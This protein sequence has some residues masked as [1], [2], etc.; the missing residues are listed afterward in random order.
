MWVIESKSQQ[1][2]L[3]KSISSI[4][5]ST[6]FCMNTLNL[7]MQKMEKIVANPEN[8][9]AN[10]CQTRDS[11]QPIQTQFLSCSCSRRHEALVIVQESG[12]SKR[13]IVKL[14]IN[15]ILFTGR[16]ELSCSAGNFRNI[17][18][19]LHR[20]AHNSVLLLESLRGRNSQTQLAPLLFLKRGCRRRQP[21]GG[22][23]ELISLS[24]Y[25]R[26]TGLSLCGGFRHI[27]ETCS[28]NRWCRCVPN[29]AM[30]LSE[31]K[32]RPHTRT[33]NSMPAPSYLS[34][35]PKMLLITWQFDDVYVIIP[36]CFQKTNP[37]SSSKGP[38]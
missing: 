16:R 22:G 2:I 12:A 33:Q 18:F 19:I 35:E 29:S 4:F 10:E 11:Y 7:T 8:A 21:C 31:T 5:F 1:T 27:P 14:K 28:L 24:E 32:H 25:Q 20:R 37:R 36:F 38:I 3:L 6:L 23:R 17:S 26:L 15:Q 34:T 30:Q 13:K 9:F